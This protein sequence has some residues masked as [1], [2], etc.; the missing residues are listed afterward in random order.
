MGQSIA[1]AVQRVWRHTPLWRVLLAVALIG[2]LVLSLMPPTPQMPT[3]G[4]DKSNHALGFGVLAF[5]GLRAWPRHTV[6]VLAALLAYGGLI[7]VLQSFTPD[8]VAEWA[9]LWADAAGLFIGCAAHWATVK[10]AG[11]P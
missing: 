8:R 9:D 1:G 6:P 3:T 5:L 2:I 7:E 11:Q 10:L 4:W